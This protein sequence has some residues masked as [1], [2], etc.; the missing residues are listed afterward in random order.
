MFYFDNNH[1]IYD[2]VEI[3]VKFCE[4]EGIAHFDAIKEE[5]TGD[6]YLLECNHR[7]WYSIYVSR[8][9]GMN[10]FQ[11][12]LD[13]MDDDQE[14]ALAVDPTVVPTSSAALWDLMRLSWTP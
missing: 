11:I 14:A 1:K 4:F 12:N 8:A 2:S 13:C 7:F 10:F 6:I 3:I 9:A 5:K